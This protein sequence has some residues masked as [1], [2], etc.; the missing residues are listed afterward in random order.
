MGKTTADAIDMLKANLNEGI[1]SFAVYD[2]SGRQTAL[3]EA[4]LTQ[5]VGEPCLASFYAF[6]G[7]STDAT[8]WKEEIST[9][10]ATMEAALPAT[11]ALP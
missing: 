8:A 11:P 9:W 6:V 2:G 5:D 10:T 3:Y 7:V 4:P 1:K